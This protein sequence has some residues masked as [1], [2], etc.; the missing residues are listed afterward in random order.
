MFTKCPTDNH[1]LHCVLREC[2]RLRVPIL[3]GRRALSGFRV[4]GLG[5]GVGTNVQVCTWHINTNYLSTWLV[6]FG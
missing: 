2:L 4:P 3:I 6:N 5:G 1:K